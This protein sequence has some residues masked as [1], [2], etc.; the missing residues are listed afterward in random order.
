MLDV[1]ND[2]LPVDALRRLRW[3]VYGFCIGCFTSARAPDGSRISS[4][5][6]LLGRISLTRVDSGGRLWP[7]VHLPRV[8]LG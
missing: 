6:N 8:I 1:G 2:F 4:V 7:R 3:V 5:K